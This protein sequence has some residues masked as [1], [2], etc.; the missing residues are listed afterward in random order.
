MA[1]NKETYQN[2]VREL[3]AKKVTLVAVS[4]TKT[5]EEIM[6]L[7]E[8]GHRDFGENYVQELTEKHF[9]LP[10]DIRWHFI[11]FNFKIVVIA[12]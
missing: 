6:E 11:G 1:V 4:K 10:K 8:L 7:Y 12:G 9:V 5:V 2:I 3:H